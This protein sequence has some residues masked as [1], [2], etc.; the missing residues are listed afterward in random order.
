MRRVL[1]EGQRPKAVATALGVCQKTVTTWVERYQAEGPDGLNDCSSR[2]HMLRKPTPDAV[3][4]RVVELRRQRWT[5]A[6]IAA[7]ASVSPATVGRILRRCGLSRL[8]DPE[9]AEPVRRYERSKPGELL[10][11]DIK[12]L[13]R[14]A[15]PGHRVTGDRT[16][17]SNTR[18][19]GWEYVHVCIDDHS[20]IAFSQIL[21]DEKKGSA[22]D[23]LKTAV[24]YF[25]ASSCLTT[26]PIR[27]HSNTK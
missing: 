12:K 2:P 26:A 24:A 14:F 27:L 16:G 15:R 17:L 13:G 18:G 5:G 8:K 1:D 25:L 21:P 10:H 19:N 22:V 11:I 23:F 3:C 20:R 9:P 7:E 4:Q 6:R